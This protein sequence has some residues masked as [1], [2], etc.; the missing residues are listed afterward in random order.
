MDSNVAFQHST[1]VVLTQQGSS[2]CSLFYSF[3]SDTVRNVSAGVRGTET[4]EA[5]GNFIPS[6][7]YYAWNIVCCFL[8]AL[9]YVWWSKVF[10]V[11]RRRRTKWLGTPI[12]ISIGLSIDH[13]I[14]IE[15][16]QDINA[17]AEGDWNLIDIPL[18]D[19]SVVRLGLR[20]YF[21]IIQER[22]CSY[23]WKITTNV[24]GV[25]HIAVS[26]LNTIDINL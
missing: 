13:F 24:A 25:F 15:D 3:H 1:K 22:C 10:N 16:P 6:Q 18:S 19:A 20:G 8:W 2:D 7:V 21:F 23:D 26:E 14:S 4:V 9:C 12:D 5:C 17:N 11:C